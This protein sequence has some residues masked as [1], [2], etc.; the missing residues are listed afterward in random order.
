MFQG[1]LTV[2]D[3][4]RKL[5]L[6]WMIAAGLEYCIL[7]T[8]L[9][10][11][12]LLDGLAQM[13][14]L[15]VC[16][17]IAIFFFGFVCFSRPKME[18]WLTVGGFFFLAVP[19]I[20]HNFTWQLLIACTLVLAILVVYASKG[21]EQKPVEV[22]ADH[23]TS[24]P[25]C[26]VIVIILAV[27]F[28]LFV[29]TWTV[30]RVLTFSTPTY[31]F[32]IFSQMFYNMKTSGLPL[33][34]VERDGLLS[35]FHVHV[36]PIY[37]LL[38]P[39]YCLFPY[40][41]TLQ[42]LQAAILASGAIPV[43]MLCKQYGIKLQ[44]RIIICAILLSYPAYAGGTSYDIH[45]NAFLTPLI[46]WLFYAFESRK[47][48]LI[49]VTSVLILCVKEDAAVY[50]AVIGIYFL[51]AGLLYRQRWNSVTG[52]CITVAALIW[53]FLVTYYLQ[54]VG[55][56]VMTY[57]YQ[58]F[59][60]DPSGSLLSVIK[61]VF[62]C[63]MK[64]LA[65]CVD[66]E[67]IPFILL[68]LLPLGAIPFFTRR[69]ERYLLLIPYI[70]VNLMSDYQYQHDIFFQYTY[71]ATGCLIYLTIVNLADLKAELGRI[72]LACT[73]LLIGIFT[74]CQQVYPKATVYTQK[75]IEYAD[76]YTQIGETLSCIPD[77]ASVTAT[78]FYTT[79]LS[80]REVLY[81]VQYATWE[82]ILSTEYVVLSGTYDR[83]YKR[84]ETDDADGYTRLCMLLE[85]AGYSI[86]T[87]WGN[88]MR[89][90]R[91]IE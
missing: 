17:L 26:I 39:F 22:A 23:D 33:T 69:F 34:T 10:C 64:A 6:S 37:Y 77:D 36:S 28:F 91:K 71:G 66:K 11:M 9:K 90:Y 25:V 45:E 48:C 41:A 16:I 81:D 7:Q 89:I 76:Y 65:E 84:Y 86:L 60:Y 51:L 58:N 70:L 80:Q 29:S 42:V 35:H 75:Y 63:P 4:I 15:R 88:T 19:F 61:A 78:T 85:N 3:C 47:Y 46:L 79:P 73:A 40:P 56:G 83:A 21:W 68:T 87:E 24:H 55:D 53:F 2:A 59:M 67:K 74:F 14:I 52:I 8:A 38:L 32:G 31:D 43:W 27:A 18:R 13:S 1:K 82:H 44:L 12:P 57:R 54:Q 30:C 50:L 72:L 62:L 49:A 20:Y 5:L